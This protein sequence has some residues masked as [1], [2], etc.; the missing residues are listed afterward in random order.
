M[1]AGGLKLSEV[2]RNEETKAGA[3]VWGKI[4]SSKVRML[5]LKRGCAGEVAENSGP[6]TETS[7]VPGVRA[8]ATWQSVGA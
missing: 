5:V 8:M 4:W 2:R 7:S 6:A 1:L 3:A